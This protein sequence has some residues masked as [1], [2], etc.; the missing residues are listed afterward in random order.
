M[1]VGLKSIFNVE[2]D[3][4]INT[5]LFSITNLSLQQKSVIDISSIFL[6]YKAQLLLF[7][8]TLLINNKDPKYRKGKIE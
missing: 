8:Y 4:F 3:L 5:K 7:A 6:Y 2:G 1:R